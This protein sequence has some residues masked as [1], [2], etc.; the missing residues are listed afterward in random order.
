VVTS[1]WR[2]FLANAKT[3]LVIKGI[4]RI[5]SNERQTLVKLGVEHF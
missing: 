1:Q 2:A 3:P 5:L 4:D